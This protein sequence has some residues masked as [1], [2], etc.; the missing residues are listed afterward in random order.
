MNNFKQGYY[1]PKNPEKYIEPE[2]KTEVRPF[3]RSSY[4][5]RVFVWADLNK[6]VKR[7]GSECIA[8]PYILYEW[9]DKYRKKLP[10][11]HKYYIDLYCEILTSQG[12]LV[13]Y[14]IEVKPLKQTEAPKPPKKKTKKSKERFIFEQATWEKNQAKWIAAQKYAVE[15]GLEFKILTETEIFNKK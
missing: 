10:K 6:N 3:F 9:S 11:K 1:T 4:E 2:G 14:I 8:I 5:E 7:W 12:K 13:K 15:N